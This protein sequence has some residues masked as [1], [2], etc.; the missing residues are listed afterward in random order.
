[1]A[2]PCLGCGPQKCLPWLM[3]CLWALELDRSNLKPVFLSTAG[4]RT[5]LPL[6]L[7]DFPYKPDDNTSSHIREVYQREPVQPS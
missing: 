5:Q 3:E 1:M 2:L 6:R 7:R 4:A